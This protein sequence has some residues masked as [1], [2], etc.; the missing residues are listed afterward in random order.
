M[1]APRIRLYRAPWCASETTYFHNFMNNF[2]VHGG[3][4]EP[5]FDDWAHVIHTM[6]IEQVRHYPGGALHEQDPW[7]VRTYSVNSLKAAWIKAKGEREEAD[8]EAVDQIMREY[9][10]EGGDFL[11]DDENEL[12]DNSPDPLLWNEFEAGLPDEWEREFEEL[13][14]PLR[15]E[16]AQEARS[17][18][19]EEAAQQAFRH[20]LHIAPEGTTH[21]ALLRPLPQEEAAAQLNAILEQPATGPPQ[22]EA[23]RDLLAR[24]GVDR[25]TETNFWATFEQRFGSR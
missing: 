11:D 2:I 16:W 18:A 7:P 12:N 23:S 10:P 14:A 15:R 24:M 3:L 1:S 20:L 21:P 25:T 4:R 19:Q 22:V 17:A 5:I 9:D 6:M 13:L 8:R